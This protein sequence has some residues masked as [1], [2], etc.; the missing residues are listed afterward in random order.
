MTFADET[1]IGRE[2]LDVFIDKDNTIYA[3]NE[4][5]EEIHIWNAD[6]ATSKKIALKQKFDPWGLFVTLDGNIYV[7]SDKNNL[8]ERW[9]LEEAQDTVVMNLTHSCAGLFVD[10]KNHFYCSMGQGHQIVKQSLDNDSDP[11]ITVAGTGIAG[12]ASN[13]LNQPRGIFVTAKLD[14]YVADCVNHRIQL[15]EFGRLNGITVT[16]S[17]SKSNINLHYPTAVFLDADGYL[18]I[19]DNGNHRIMVLRSNGL[20]CIIGCSAIPGSKSNQLHYPY[21]A[22]FDSFGNIFVADQ[23]NH[24]IQKFNLLSD[25]SGK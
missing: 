25:T 8:V 19:V 17:V 16:E 23:N 3:I 24:R 21:A 15:F 18:F 11:F 5:H 20:C 12:F 6:S 14:L 7:S 22:A 2:P 9:T 13:M 10:I 1:V 4:Y